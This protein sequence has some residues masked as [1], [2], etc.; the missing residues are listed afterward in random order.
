MQQNTDNNKS[1]SIWGRLVYML[2][3]G[4]IFSV[5]ETVVFITTLVAFVTKLLSG[6]VNVS[7][8]MFGKNLGTYLNQIVSFLTFN[9]EEHPFPLSAWPNDSGNTDSDSVTD[10]RKQNIPEKTDTNTNNPV[11]EPTVESNG[12]DDTSQADRQE[13]KTEGIE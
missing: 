11:D 9:S 5:A 12:D 13:K 8:L 1:G 4:L 10:L 7:V 3:F 6:S 2:L